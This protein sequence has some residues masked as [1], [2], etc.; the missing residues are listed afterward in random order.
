MM[1]IRREGEENQSTSGIIK[2]E[3]EKKKKWNTQ[4]REKSGKEQKR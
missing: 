4:R 3:E 1:K 2:I